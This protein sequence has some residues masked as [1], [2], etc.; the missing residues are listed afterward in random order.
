MPS[1]QAGGMQPA[2]PADTQPGSQAGGPAPAKGGT[3]EPAADTEDFQPAISDEELVAKAV[4]HGCSEEDAW[5]ALRDSKA[6]KYSIALA[7]TFMLAGH[8]AMRPGQAMEYGRK[9]G[10]HPFS[11]SSAAAGF[12]KMCGKDQFVH[13]GKSKYVLRCLPGVIEVPREKPGGTKEGGNSKKS[14]K[15]APMASSGEAVAGDREEAEDEE[16]GGEGSA[17]EEMGDA[18]EEAQEEEAEVEADDAAE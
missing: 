16:A 1:Q 15:S 4:A 6:S 13:V 14:G 17:D 7:R 9:M 3:A 11:G 12:S 10:L 5:R 8:Q 2:S 18:S